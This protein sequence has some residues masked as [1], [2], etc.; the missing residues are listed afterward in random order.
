MVG[1]KKSQGV[2]NVALNIA[3]RL[4][5]FEIIYL[6]PPN[7]K[8]LYYFFLSPIWF[9]FK[10]RKINPDVVM[11]HSLEASF[12][13]VIAK[14]IF[15]LKYGILTVAHG[16]NKSVFDVYL[17]EKKKGNVKG[18][19]IFN[20]S[21]RI[22]NL[23]SFFSKFSDIVTAIS[24][25]V[26]KELKKQYGINAIVVHNG[27]DFKQSRK[28]RKK[29]DKI[30]FVGNSYWRKGL[31]YLI[32]ANNLLKKPKEI[33]VVGLASGP[34]EELR[35][36]VNCTNVHF[37]KQMSRKALWKIYLECDL[38]AMPSLYES[39]GLVYLEAL[40][41]KMPVIASK[42][43][44]AED[45]IKT[46]F[47]GVLVRKAYVG[48]IKAA[49]IYCEKNIKRLSNNAKLQPDFSWE[50]IAKEYQSLLESLC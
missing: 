35:G 33:V 41:T 10:V 38:F 49:I 3:E 18:S 2:G 1:L 50:I 47:N 48:D 45:I 11:V 42:G 12:D 36:I 16:S 8:W 27:G 20:L 13:P 30:L 25:S 5:N 21:L 24:F 14:K 46:G 6:Y 43:T 44:G 29:L 28:K 26:K 37:K 15:F 9:F 40:A 34:E 17:S 22:S 31:F 32:L 39:F 19:A 4:N 23:R 7:K